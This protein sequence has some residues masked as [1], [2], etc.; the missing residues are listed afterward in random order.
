M[1]THK[2]MPGTTIYEAAVEMIS[3]ANATGDTVMVDFNEVEI[4]ANPG[5]EP[6]SIV[7]TYHERCNRRAEAY[8]N[9]PKGKRAA[10]EAEERKRSAQKTI[11]E[12][13]VELRALDFGS[14][15]AVINWLDKI[16]DPSDHIGVY[17]PRYEILS[18]FSENGFEPNVYCG[19]D[20]DGDNEEVVARWLIGQAL[21]T[22]RDIGAIH[23]MI[24]KFADD[25]RKKFGH[26]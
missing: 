6:N 25:W 21:G 20:H 23:P 15:A 10:A 18:A 3:I 19:E 17:V 5:D 2:P 22:L 9:S 13:M 12:A 4:T 8:R 11:N 7:A 26:A 24:S 14:F 1:Q 16:C